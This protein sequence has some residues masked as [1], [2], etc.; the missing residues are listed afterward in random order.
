MNGDA[1]QRPLSVG[2]CLSL[3]GKYARF[4][5]QAA[6]ALRLWQSMDGAVDLILED[7]ESDR[8]TLEAT[9]PHVASRCDLLLGPYSTQLMKTAGRIAAEEDWLLWNHGGSGDDVEAA[10]P[11]HVIS[12]LTP[13]SRYSKPFLQYLANHRQR[14]TL[15][16]VHGKGSFGRQVATGAERLAAQLNLQTA[17]I[18]PEDKLT[19]STLPGDW[20]LLTA[21]SFEEDIETVKHARSLPHPPRTI[22]AVAAGVREFGDQVENAE[23]IFGIAQWFPGSRQTP[24]LGPTEEHFLV[25]YSKFTNATPPDYPAIQATAAGILAAHC[26]RRTG[27][28]TQ[29]LWSG[30]VALDTD[31]LF[32]GFKIDPAT[33]AQTKHETVL[34]HWTAKGPTAL[35]STAGP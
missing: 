1:D 29:H 30:A 16:I 27:E 25:A 3:S 9:L 24:K 22:C 13:T 5:R 10:R 8:R 21:G 19:P 35:A 33:G 17:R 34:V 15:V 7:D 23:G 2:A 14:A 26:A 18:G 6:Q 12:V 28:A 32:G 20:D 4:G 11:G 31:T